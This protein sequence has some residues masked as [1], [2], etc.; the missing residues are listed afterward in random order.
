MKAKNAFLT[1]LTLA[2]FAAS[3]WAQTAGPVTLASNEANGTKA[4]PAAA[5]PAAPPS[6]ITA[7]DVQALKDALA[8]QQLEIER[9]SQQLDRQQAQQ[10]AADAAAANNAANNA[11]KA[12]QTKDVAVLASPVAV[13]QDST[14]PGLNLQDAQTPATNPMESPV[15]AIH[16][17]G[18]SITPGGYVEA[19]FVRRSRALGADLPTPFNSLTMPGAS[20]SQLSEFFGS[21]RQ[22]KIT[23]FVDGRLNNVDLS[24]YVS[25]DFLSSGDTSTSN[26]TNSYT[27]RLRQFW[28]QA[29]FDNG[30]SFV[31]GQMW[32]L[33][34]EDAK[35]ISPDD[36]LGRTNDVRPKVIDPS[37]NVGFTFARQYGVRVTKSFGQKVAA[38][39]SM[40][41]PQ[42]TLS[43]HGN[44]NN[45]LLGSAGASN[46][47]NDAVTGC[48][49]SSYTVTGA[50]SPTYYT[51]CTP[52]G[53]YTFN[54]SPDVIAKL[55]FDPGF[56]H[57]E[58][59]GLYDRFRDRVFPC[60]N[61]VLG[62]TGPCPNDPTKTGPSG[63]G[64]YNVSKNGGAF[65]ANA[66]WGFDHKHMDFGLHFFGGRGVGRYGA[67]G[68][69]DLAIHADGTPNLIKN[70]QGLASLE[71]HGKKLD[72]YTYAGAEYD[73]RAQDYDSATKAY[74]GYGSPFFNNSGCYTETAPSTAFTSGFNPGS[75]S[76]CTADTRA[77]IEGTAGFWYRFYNGPRGRFQFGTQYSYVTR[78]TWSGIGPSGT[79][80]PGVTPEG[81]D[82]MVFT[83]FRYYLP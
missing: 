27:L 1:A 28:G 78:Q 68:L 36:D 18:I 25:A 22:S 20:Q 44:P 39:V 51:T 47:Y 48:S 4:A 41:N 83:S 40:E 33:V 74:V 82:G 29:K 66:R 63:L 8:A 69:A 43:T 30:F 21:A 2:A 3:G 61:F 46:S 80:A 60:A 75:L 5:A 62:T 24:S 73:G 50:T 23:T 42:G 54:P 56:G 67:G 53:T 12:V 34:T 70:G 10:A 59:F 17:R 13:Q 26:Q 79:G 57:Y 77:L 76:K 6:I 45:F 35:G 7:A 49:T 38:A 19:A 16:F 64:A 15:I 37:Y 72:L 65:G 32:S 14:T 55:A 71:W 81:L 11:A 31:G 9:L 52:A 58:I